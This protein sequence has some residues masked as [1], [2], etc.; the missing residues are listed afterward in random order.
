[1]VEACVPTRSREELNYCEIKNILFSRFYGL[2]T[3]SFLYYFIADL[4]DFR[5]LRDLEVRIFDFDLFNR[6]LILEEFGKI[7]TIDPSLL[8]VTFLDSTKYH[9]I[10]VRVCCITFLGSFSNK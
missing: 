6:F 7:Q 3:S 2:L 8:T 5:G 9:N 4:V 1:M 10:V